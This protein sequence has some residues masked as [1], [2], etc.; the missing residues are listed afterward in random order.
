MYHSTWLNGS[1]KGFLTSSYVQVLNNDVDNYKVNLQVEFCYFA[2]GEFATKPAGKHNVSI[3]IDVVEENN[4]F[5]QIIKI[6]NTGTL[7]K[8]I[9]IGIHDDPN[10]NESTL[11]HMDIVKSCIDFVKRQYN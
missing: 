2:Y 5:R 11:D 10:S 9:Q 4:E 6:D 7:L 3:N 1:Y 8:D